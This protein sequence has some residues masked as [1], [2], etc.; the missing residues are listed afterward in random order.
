MLAIHTK[1]ELIMLVIYESP[2]E[3]HTPFIHKHQSHSQ[4]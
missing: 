1:S 3:D 2:V 4:S